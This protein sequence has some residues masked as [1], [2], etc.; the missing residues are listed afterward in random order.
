MKTHVTETFVDQS[1]KDINYYLLDEP[2]DEEQFAVLERAKYKWRGYDVDAKILGE[3][4]LF[5]VRGENDFLQEI[6]ACTDVKA[7]ET[8]LIINGKLS[9]YSEAI[10]HRSR[11]LAYTFHSFY[12]EMDTMEESLTKLL[13]IINDPNTE[14]NQH[15]FKSGSDIYKFEP[16]TIVDLALDHTLT[17]R[18]VHTYPNEGVFV[19]TKSLITEIDIL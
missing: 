16:T 1:A 2:V 9:G 8:S 14:T 3:S 15:I 19:F 12:C 13:N 5:S 4:H 6:C 10:T 7:H 17:V 18:T 11:K